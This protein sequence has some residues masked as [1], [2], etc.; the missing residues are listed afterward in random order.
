M[1]LI[2][3]D[4]Y[5]S[6]NSVPTVRKRWFFVLCILFFIP[7]AIVIAATGEVYALSKGEVM[8]FS[9]GHKTMIIVGWSALLVMNV[10]R[11]LASP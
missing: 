4:E 3:A 5:E 9:S 6:Y 8:K 2:K 1:A 10:L 11:A 7:A